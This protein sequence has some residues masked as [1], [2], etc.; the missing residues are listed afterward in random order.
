[1]SAKKLDPQRIYHIKIRQDD[2][3]PLK[4]V[5]KWK[6]INRIVIN[7]SWFLLINF[8]WILYDIKCA[9][10]E[11]T[12]PSVSFVV[13]FRVDRTETLEQQFRTTFIYHWT[14]L[15]KIIQV[16]KF[17]ISAIYQHIPFQNTNQQD[18]QIYCGKIILITHQ[19]NLILSRLEGNQL[20][21]WRKNDSIIQKRADRILWSWWYLIWLNPCRQIYCKNL[22]P[23]L[24]WAS[25]LYD[26]QAI[27]PIRK[28][29]IVPADRSSG[30]NFFLAKQFYELYWNLYES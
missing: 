29:Q 2:W 21:A 20:W 18:S 19:L 13:S 17:R 14:I 15:K 9:N 28:E 5:F 30:W 16:T 11:R 23:R 25:D 27:F 6:N 22:N 24:L 4:T 3:S 26:Q 7:P 10:Y 1:M 8:G 12:E